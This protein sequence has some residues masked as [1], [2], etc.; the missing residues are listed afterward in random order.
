ME[1]LRMTS[2]PTTD[3]R[4]YDVLLVALDGG[5][6]LALVPD[7]PD[8]VIRGNSRGEALRVAADAIAAYLAD[9][10]AKVSRLPDVI[11]ERVTVRV[12]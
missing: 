3:E 11:H 8:V 1:Q 2:N 9:L 10:R 6:F 5:G 12:G 4:E 7:L